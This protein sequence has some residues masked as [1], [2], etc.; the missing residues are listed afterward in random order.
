M[1]MDLVVIFAFVSMVVLIV[2][3]GVVLFPIS[4]RLGYFL[5]Q[6]TR[7]RADRLAGGVREALSGP[8]AND[9]LLRALSELQDQVAQLAERQAFTEQ[10]LEHRPEDRDREVDPVEG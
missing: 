1:D 8:A 9:R 7:E 4:R 2:T 3:G 6:A 10:L 5:E